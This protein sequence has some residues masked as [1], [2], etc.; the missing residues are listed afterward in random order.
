MLV[1]GPLVKVSDNRSCVIQNLYV[2]I[3]RLTIVIS[4]TSNLIN[5]SVQECETLL[6]YKLNNQMPKDITNHFLMGEII[7]LAIPL[8]IAF[9]ARTSQREIVFKKFLM[10]L[11]C[12]RSN[13]MRIRRAPASDH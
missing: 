10:I 9:C 2:W 7:S 8:K 6:L 4:Y 3:M 13:R 12:Q 5:A 11:L 1:I